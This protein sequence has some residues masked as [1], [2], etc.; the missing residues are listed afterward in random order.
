[1]MWFDKYNKKVLFADKRFE[2]KDMT[3]Y[4]IN[5]VKKVVIQI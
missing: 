5:L 2:E 3:A 4:K 1:M